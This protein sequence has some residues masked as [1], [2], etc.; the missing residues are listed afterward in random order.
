MAPLADE[1]I[2]EWQNRSRAFSSKDRKA[3][4]TPLRELDAHLTLRSNIVG[5]SQTDADIVVWTA[6]RENH[7]ASAFIKQGTYINLTRWFK[8]IEETNPSIALPQRVGKEAKGGKEKE[9]HQEDSYDIGLQDVEK[10][11]ITRFPPEPSGCKSTFV[12]IRL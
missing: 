9:K 7:L 8:F 3:L 1:Q 11:V 4:E 10:G 2:K 5:Y 12:S 6:I